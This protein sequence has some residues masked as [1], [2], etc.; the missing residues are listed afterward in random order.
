MEKNEKQDRELLLAEAMTVSLRAIAA[1]KLAAEFY[2]QEER[3][4]RIAQYDQLQD[5]RKRA[6]DK[7]NALPH[8][9]KYAEWVA[10][11]GEVAANQKKLVWEAHQRSANRH[12]EALGE[13]EKEHPLIIELF[14]ARKDVCRRD[15][16]K[17]SLY[18]QN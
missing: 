2:T 18:H 4:Q 16:M 6:F 10:S 15:N 3:Q 8:V 5:E 7:W 1:V 12:S 13:F 14:I 17:R 9:A 11:E